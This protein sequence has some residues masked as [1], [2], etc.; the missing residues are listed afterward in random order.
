MIGYLGWLSRR[1]KAPDRARG[2]ARA[3]CRTASCRLHVE[4]LEDRSLPGNVLF[5]ALL[6]P[7]WQA[8]H[9]PLDD[10]ADV[11]AI[12]LSG[13]TATASVTPALQPSTPPSDLDALGGAAP[14]PI[15]ETRT[16][17]FGGP[18]IH[19]NKPGLP[20]DPPPIGNEP[21]TINNFN[22]FIGVVHATGTGTDG[23]GNTL[24][25]DADLRFMTGV[26]QGLDG[27]LH[28]GTFAFV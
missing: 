24:S 22:G 10:G 21:S 3:P 14:M 6:A 5:G 7:P 19:F 17:P 2:Q 12:V 23:S 18:A 1:I 8:P 26:Y 9:S 28:T 25:W 11:A 15:P 4:K 27:D 20:T 13:S 16:N